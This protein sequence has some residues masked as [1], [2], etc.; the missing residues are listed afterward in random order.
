MKD[1]TLL[2]LT[3]AALLGFSIVHKHATIGCPGQDSVQVECKIIDGSKAT[4][5]LVTDKDALVLYGDEQLWVLVA[6][7]RRSH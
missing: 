2:S 7:L 6:D 1:W 5:M 4:W 3:I